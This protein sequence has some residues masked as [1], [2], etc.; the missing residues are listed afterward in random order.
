MASLIG[1]SK[2][3]FSMYLLVT[4]AGKC[5]YEIS[6]RRQFISRKTV[7]ESYKTFELFSK[8][9]CLSACLHDACR[10]ICSVACYNKATK[11]CQL[12]W[13]DKSVFDAEDDAVGVMYIRCKSFQKIV[14]CSCKQKLEIL[15]V[16]LQ[17]LD[18]LM[19]R[20]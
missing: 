5:P 6:L 10:G 19:P 3:L 11:V 1:L 18:M 14:F 9:Q 16:L 7:L 2:C 4:V 8:Q 15:L 13:D 12:S 20:V 17:A